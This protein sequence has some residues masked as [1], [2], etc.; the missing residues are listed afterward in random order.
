LE[1]SSKIVSHASSW[2]V[3]EHHTMG[4]IIISTKAQVLDV[5]GNPIPKLYVAGEATGGIH[6]GTRLGSCALTD[7]IVIGRTAGREVAKDPLD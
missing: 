2:L 4:E 5:N 3:S 7:C 6:G 1:N